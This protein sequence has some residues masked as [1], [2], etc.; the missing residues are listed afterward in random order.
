MS[1][2]RRIAEELNLWA[3]GEL[4]LMGGADGA[5]MEELMSEFMAVPESEAQPTDCKRL[6]LALCLT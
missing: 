3:K 5:A 1:G 4:N 6:I 2:A